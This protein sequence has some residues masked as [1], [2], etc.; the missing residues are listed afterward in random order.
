MNTTVL[1]L[2]LALTA[3]PLL[4]EGLAFEPTTPDGLDATALERVAVLQTG[5]P[6]QMPAFEAQGYTAWGAIL[7][8]QGV[9]ITPQTLAAVQGLPDAEAATAEGLKICAQQFGTDCTVIGL[10]VPG[11]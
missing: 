7:V 9:E 3:T 1:A 11:D 6:G 2:G 4:G 10:L 8:P 5:L